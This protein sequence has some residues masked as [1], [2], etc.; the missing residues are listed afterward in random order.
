MTRT[1]A[2]A[3]A[4]P[5]STKAERAEYGKA[6]RQ[7]VPLQ[8]HAELITSDGGSRRRQMLATFRYNGDYERLGVAMRP[9]LVVIRPE[10]VEGP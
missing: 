6:V 1:T 5:L 8:A 4:P 9:E 7:Q 3:A 10:P 2:P